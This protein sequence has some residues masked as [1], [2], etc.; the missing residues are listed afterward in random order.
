MIS[1][2]LISPAMVRRILISATVTVATALVAPDDVARAQTSSAPAL[3]SLRT[4]TIPAAPVGHRQP[5]RVRLP[6]NAQS[7]ESSELSSERDFDQ[8]LQICRG[9]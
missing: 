3:D 1:F 4:N 5:A 8:Q 9:C 2:S 6:S 7:L